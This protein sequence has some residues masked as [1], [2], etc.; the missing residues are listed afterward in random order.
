LKSKHVHIVAF[1]VPFPA[2]YGGAYA[3]FY[4]IKALHEKGVKIH[5]HCFEYGRGQ[6]KALE[7]YCASVTYYERAEGP[8]GF[9]FTLPYIVASRNNSKLWETLQNDNYP[10]ILEGIHSTYG[11]HANLLTSRKVILYLHNVEFEYYKQLSKWERSLMKKT[12]FHHESRL[13]ERYERQ[14][15]ARCTIVSLSEKDKNTYKTKLGASDIIY[16]PVFVDSNKI[17]AN[18]GN[19]NY[20][21]YHGNLSVA[22]NEKAAFW[23]LEKIFNDMDIPLVIAGKNPP[24]RLIKLCHKRPT[25]CII[26]NPDEHEMN[27]LISKAHLHILP[28][29]TDSGIKLKLINALFKGRHVIVNEAMVA[30]TKLEKACHIADS[31]AVMKYQIYRLFQI[32]FTKEDFN[33]RREIL[34]EVFD[35]ERQSQTLIKLLFE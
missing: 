33:K 10:I 6:Q 13:L 19:G 30:G 32:A 31:A 27:D 3:I 8:K 35:Q 28:S 17:N 25:T 21:L 9:S 14:I 18:T 22:E 5:L 15:A 12:Y 29:Y 20:A 24:E 16:L 11:L 7:L 23:L 1:D 2:D 34:D 4:K 26:A